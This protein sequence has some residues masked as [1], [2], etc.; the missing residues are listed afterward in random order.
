VENPKNVWLRS[1]AKTLNSIM[2]KV[3]EERFKSSYQGQLDLGV[4]L[5]MMKGM[6]NEIENLQKENDDLKTKVQK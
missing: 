6:M 2:F 5:F 1:H 3:E 4:V